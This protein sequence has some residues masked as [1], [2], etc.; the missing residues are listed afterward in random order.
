[1]SCQ[2]FQY[3]DD[4]AWSDSV[5]Y[6]TGGDAFGNIFCP[7]LSD[8]APNPLVTPP[9]P[10]HGSTAA[11][12]GAAFQIGNFQIKYQTPL[13][14]RRLRLSKPTLQFS[15][16]LSHR[17]AYR[18]SAIIRFLLVRQM[19]LLPTPGSAP[20]AMQFLFIR[21]QTLI[22]YLSDSIP[23][24]KRDKRERGRARVTSLMLGNS[25]LFVAWRRAY[26]KRIF[27]SLYR[28][29]VFRSKWPRISRAHPD[30]HTRNRVHTS[31]VRTE[32]LR[33]WCRNGKSQYVCAFKST[34]SKSISLNIDSNR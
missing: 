32:E 20:D 29:G 8:Y 4:S 13:Q 16:F 34:Q 22:P 12:S 21:S 7:F 15:G 5:S 6:R 1:M 30:I 28:N 31:Q 3:V 2:I 24:R 10:S 27:L 14:S 19:L 11:A 9:P 18:L 33:L 17:F 23:L 26:G 25:F